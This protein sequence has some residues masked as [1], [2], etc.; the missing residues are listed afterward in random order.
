MTCTGL[1]I[2]QVEIVNFIAMAITMGP[3]L[4]AGLYVFARTT[5]KV[6]SQYQT[7]HGSM[8]RRIA[9]NFALIPGLIAFVLSAAFLSLLTQH[10]F[11]VFP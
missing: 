2:F 3:A 4:L 5:R 1:T 6:E 7:R 10:L 9:L 11:C 8:E